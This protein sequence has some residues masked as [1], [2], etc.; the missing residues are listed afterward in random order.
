MGNAGWRFFDA[1]GGRIDVVPPDHIGPSLRPLVRD[2]VLDWLLTDIGRS[3]AAV[4]RY[5]SH[6]NEAR[7]A[8]LEGVSGNGT[9]QTRGATGVVLESLYEQW[10]DVTLSDAD[11]D[12]VLDDYEAFL[13]ARR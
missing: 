2:A 11:F 9:A 4:A 3:P 12:R 5:R 13:A 10:D 7:T 6:W 8:G 1:A